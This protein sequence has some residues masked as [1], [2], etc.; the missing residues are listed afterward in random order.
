MILFRW[1]DPERVEACKRNSNMLA[2][3]INKHDPVQMNLSIRV[4]HTNWIW[5][6]STV[7]PN[8]EA[9]LYG[10]CLPVIFNAQYDAVS[11]TF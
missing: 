8:V 9:Q 3:T 4:F 7:C 5:D 1:I 11:L 10:M 2:S 6:V